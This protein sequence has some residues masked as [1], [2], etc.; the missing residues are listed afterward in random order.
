MKEGQE[1]RPSE[2]YQIEELS[3]GTSILTISSTY[4]EDTGTITF[5]AQNSLGVAETVTEITTEGILIVF[6]DSLK[7]YLFQ[8]ILL[9]MKDIITKTGY[10]VKRYATTKTI[11]ESPY[12][13]PFI[14]L[15]TILLLMT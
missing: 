6:Y 11:S 4:P 12:S 10:G 14:I 8:S 9:K 7:V 2:E 5:E 1:I 3:D 15:S 13:F